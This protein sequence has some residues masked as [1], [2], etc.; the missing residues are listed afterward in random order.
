MFKP[1]DRDNAIR[2][3]DFPI[4]HPAIQALMPQIRQAVLEHAVLRERLFQVEFLVS[5]KGEKLVTLIYHKKLQ[6]DWIDCATELAQALNIK[7]IGR[8]RKQ[9]VCIGDDFIHESLQVNGKSYQYEQVEASFTQ[10]NAFVNE[11]M[12]SWA[13]QQLQGSEGDLLELYCGNGN[14]TSVL[15]EHFDKVLATE[16]SKSSVKAADYSFKQNG[17]DNVKICR[18]ASE[19]LTQAMNQERTFKRLQQQAINIDD[20]AFSTVFVDPPRAGLDDGTLQLCQNFEQI[21]YISC[22]P[23]SLADNL[24]RLCQTHDIVSCALFDQ[25]PYTQHIESGVLLQIKK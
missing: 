5:L 23:I 3:D 16:I 12:L 24:Q 15:A 9:K 1:G 2:I 13:Q 6:Q 19:E 14:F 22:N 10:P 21:L 7:L 11:K 18:M 25:F 8:S 20:Y 17:I 4:A